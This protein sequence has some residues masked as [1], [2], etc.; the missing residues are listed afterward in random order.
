MD[1]IQQ[2]SMFTRLPEMMTLSTEVK[3]PSGIAY[4][5]KKLALD[6]HKRKDMMAPVEANSSKQQ[7]VQCTTVGSRAQEQ[8]FLSIRENENSF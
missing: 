6:A 8:S 4:E 1:A 2:S 3:S 5:R 7:M